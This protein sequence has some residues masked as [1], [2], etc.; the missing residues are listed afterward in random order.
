[1][2]LI[3]ILINIF[4]LQL[5]LLH[6]KTKFFSSKISG[7]C[8]EE[9]FVILKIISD[10]LCSKVLMATHVRAQDPHTM[11]KFGCIS[12]FS[13]NVVQ[14]LM[15]SG[16]LIHFEVITHHGWPLLYFGV[17]THYHC[18]SLSHFWVITQHGWPLIHFGVMICQPK[19]LV[20]QK[21]C[22]HCVSYELMINC[23]YCGV[24]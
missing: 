7:S 18:W 6:I 17:I 23:K 19:A 10:C 20:T 5:L 21:D 1:M 2:V 22:C 11:F 3:N 13:V 15:G 12:I 16:P 9:M 24:M 4:D 8:P 14:H